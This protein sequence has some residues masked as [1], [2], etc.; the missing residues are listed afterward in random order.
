M[1][2]AARPT[3]EAVLAKIYAYFD[4]NLAEKPAAPVSEQ[5]HLIQDLRLDSMQSFEMVSDLEDH[6]GITMPMELF[7]HV[8]TVGDVA[9]EVVKVIAQDRGEA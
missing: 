5:S 4:E 7:Q 9:R 1:T 2:E 8:V 6:F 3:Y